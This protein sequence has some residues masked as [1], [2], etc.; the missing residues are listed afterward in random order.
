MEVHLER[1][2]DNTRAKAS[3]NIVVSGNT[4][5]ITTTYNPPIVLDPKRKYE[6]ALTNLDTYY[7]FPNIDDTNNVFRYKKDKGQWKDIKIPIGCYEIKA[8]REEVHR[9]LGNEEDILIKANLNTLKC[10][11]I[12]EKGYTIDFNV[13]HSLAMVLGFEK[14]Q[15]SSGRHSSE[16]VVNILRINSILVHTDIVTNSY[17]KGVMTPVVY[18]FFPDVS[19]G[20]KIISAPKN[21]VYLPITLNTIYYM[22]TWLTDQDHRPLDLRGEELTIRFH[23]REC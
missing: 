19:P 2:A 14:K 5:S 17:I 11:L 20:V 10:M 6:I 9:Q 12:I 22:K 8:I 3:M 4:N 16:H 7:S 18:T 13:P 23:F 21:L 1:I 15:Y